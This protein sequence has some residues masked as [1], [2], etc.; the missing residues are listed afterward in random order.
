[1]DHRVDGRDEKLAAGEVR[2]TRGAQLPGRWAAGGDVGVEREEVVAARQPRR[3]DGHLRHR[4]ELAFDAH[5]GARRSCRGRQREGRRG[6]VLRQC[7]GARG[8]RGAARGQ[9][10]ADRE[11]YGRQDCSAHRRL[12]SQPRAADRGRGA[13]VFRDD[14]AATPSFVWS[15]NPRGPGWSGPRSARPRRGAR[16][17][18]RCAQD[19]RA[20]RRLRGSPLV[21][22]SRACDR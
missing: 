2:R 4:G 8:Q 18:G 1:V 12:P 20:G 22:G 15:G 21:A 17:A 5:L 14:A 9:R 7:D 13:R 19:R 10:S 3:P 6:D 16:A 11:E